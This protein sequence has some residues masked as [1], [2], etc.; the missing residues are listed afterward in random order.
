MSEEKVQPQCRMAGVKYRRRRH[1][2]DGVEQE[3][4]LPD[5]FFEGRA[6]HD[7]DI[8]SCKIILTGDKAV[9]VSIGAKADDR[10]PATQSVVDLSGVRPS[11]RRDGQFRVIEKPP[12]SE[13]ASKS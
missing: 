11:Q 12:L 6:R 3:P 4:V 2:L 9:L 1:R 10:Q 13:L 8:G 7:Q 5:D